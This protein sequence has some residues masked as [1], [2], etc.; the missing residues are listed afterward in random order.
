MKMDGEGICCAFAIPLRFPGGAR[1]RVRLQA[2]LVCSTCSIMFHPP[3]LGLVQKGLAML[4]E[5]RNATLQTFRR[6]RA[7]TCFAAL[8]GRMWHTKDP[9]GSPPRIAMDS[10]Y[11]PTHT[12]WQ[13]TRVFIKLDQRSCVSTALSWWPM[14]LPGIG[15]SAENFLSCCLRFRAIYSSTS[16]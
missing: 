7:E 3:C 16:V 2:F 12:V 8:E 15:C 13:S 9:M 5:N 14:Y 1:L 11:N 4:E 10:I 6:I